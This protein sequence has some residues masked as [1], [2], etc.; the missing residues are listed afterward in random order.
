[1]GILD[2]GTAAEGLFPALSMRD[3]VA[4]R[5]LSRR[6]TAGLIR[7]DAERK[8]VGHVLDM[9]GV[10]HGRVARRPART[11][12][13]GDQQKVLIAGWLLT[14]ARALLLFDVTHG[15]DA[16]AKHAVHELVVDLAAQGKAVLYYSS[17]ADELAH[18]C[19]RVIVLHD[20]QI[21][22]ELTGPIGG[23]ERIIAASLKGTAP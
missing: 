23:A 7:F 6:S 19:H 15:L 11:L 22:A 20:G 18:L 5:T 14:E 1:V 16:A 12:P 13:A 8:A 4:M 17:D 21:C 10:G 9:V 2:E 3:N